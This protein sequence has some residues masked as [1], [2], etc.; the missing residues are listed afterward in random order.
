MKVIIVLQCVGKWT[1]GLRDYIAPPEEGELV[2]GKVHCTSYALFSAGGSDHSFQTRDPAGKRMIRIDG[3][4][5]AAS[6]EVFQY[7]VLMLVGAG[8]LCRSSRVSC[9][10]V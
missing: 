7:K 1:K 4:F 8:M 10:D 2:L 5:G 3:P 9:V 6:E